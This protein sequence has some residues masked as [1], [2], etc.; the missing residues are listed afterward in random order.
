MRIG[1][2]GQAYTARSVILG[3]EECI[4]FYPETLSSR[5]SVSQSTS[6]GGSENW[7]QFKGLLWTPGTKL[8]CTLDDSPTR[9]DCIAGNSAFVVAGATLYQVNADGTFA[10]RGSVAND[11]LP[12]SLVA[13]AIQVLIVS[14]GHAYCLTLSDNSIVDVT[15]QLAGTPIRVDYSDSY[16]IVFFGGTNKFQISSPLD[17]TIWPGLNVNEVSVFPENI[18]SI[19]VSHREL[20]V[21]GQQHIQP[22]QDT[23]STEIFDPIPG[24]LIEKGSAAS[25]APCRVDNTVFWIDED[26]RGGRSAWRASGYTPQR[27]STYGVE[28]AWE[29][30]STVSDAVS[31]SYQ[32]AGHLFWVVYFPASDCSWVYDVSEQSWHK[33]GYWLAA[34]SVFEPHHSWNHVYIW[35][36]H[37]VGDWKTGNIYEMNSAFL[38]DA[39][40]NIRRMRRTPIVE[41][42]MKWVP[43]PALTVDMDT[44]LGPQPPLTDGSGNP[45]PPQAMLRWSDDRGHTWSNE[46]WADCGFAGEYQTRAIWRR[47]GRSRY[48]VYEFSVTDPIAWCVTGAFVGA[49]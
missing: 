31:Y 15:A 23:G 39:G 43:H 34:N 7:R 36:K 5:T 9:G 2:V 48:R 20:W 29:A 35:S 33:R 19:V 1:L 42:E 10:S 28:V 21:M 30:L 32:E 26:E 37:L 17:G 11:G 12:A 47:L 18:S 49:A 13:S 16:F 27:I 45:R 22:Y 46:H 4:N 44:G 38:D 41:N 14:G 25:F 24:A 40:A 3:G 8:F 6:Y